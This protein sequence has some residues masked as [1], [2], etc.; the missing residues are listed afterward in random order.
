MSKAAFSLETYSFDKVNID[1]SKK[2]S[3]DFEI[4]FS[5]SGKF[6]SNDQIFELTFTFLAHNGNINEPFVMVECIANYKFENK[7]LFN[8]I[9]PYF[10]QNSIAII[11]PYVRSF[12]STV[13][14]QANSNLILLPT[15]NLSSL[16]K[17]LK[18]N[19]VSI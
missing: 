6:L 18:E 19:T 5:P 8:E 1:F 12:I 7:I 14:L 17:P 9:P 2:T 3:S 16:E 15:L 4:A 10:Y 11:F 13:T